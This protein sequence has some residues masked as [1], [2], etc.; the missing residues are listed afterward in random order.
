MNEDFE[1]NGG[2][3][4][5]FMSDARYF[6]FDIMSVTDIVEI[7]TITKI[8]KTPE[9]LKGVMNHRGKAVPVMDL[10]KRLALE[11]FEYTKKS[12]VIV[13]QIDS[14][15]MGMLV[16]EVFDVEDISPEQITPS[17]A[18]DGVVGYFISAGDRRISLLNS[19]RLVRGK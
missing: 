12:C 6:A 4:L 13:L 10:R 15:Q 17:P 9:Y 7:P 1:K 8:P 11:D 5:T 16:D 2:K 18:K 19:A 3:I 14:M